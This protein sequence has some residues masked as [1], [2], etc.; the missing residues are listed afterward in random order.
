MKSASRQSLNFA[1]YKTIYL[2]RRTEQTIVDNYSS[3]E[4]KTPM[5][6]S[7]GSEAIAAGICLAMKGHDFY[8]TYRSHALYL[9]V[10]QEVEMFFAEMYGKA[11]G[12]LKG[13]GGSMHLMAP[14][15]GLLGVSAVVASTIPVAVGTAF[16]N[17]LKKNGK[18]VCVFFGDGAVDEGVFWESLNIACLK[19]LPVLFV[20]E[21]NNLAVHTTKDQ[22]RGYK[23]LKKIVSAYDCGVFSSKSTEPEAI[24]TLTKKAF[25]FIKNKSRPAFL[26]LSYYR[27]LE[28]VGV[29]EDFHTG[30][31]DKREFLKWQK[32]DPLIL[33][34]EKLKK[35]G[36]I[37]QK[38]KKAEQI[39]EEK[40][41]V[42]LQNAQKAP[43]PKAEELYKNLFSYEN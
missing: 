11:T 39:I 6:M 43:F 35:L 38:I 8:G 30:Y 9:A 28:H 1:L 2:I 7:M 26:E 15:E 41:T 29:N 36:L 12:T 34:R 13:K 22:R 24:F 42:A 10:T 23:D 14:D 3:D 32:K 18:I 37:E 19:K 5:H 21:D 40:I 33:Q 25:E 16:V 17:K 27:Y 4:M 20:C 31:R